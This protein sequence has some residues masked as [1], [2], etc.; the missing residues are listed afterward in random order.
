[1]MY[2][3]V[4]SNVAVKLFFNCVNEFA[5]LLLAKES[6]EDGEAIG[7]AETKWSLGPHL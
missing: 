1:M 4:I 5:K 2:L 6:R 3:E 7:F